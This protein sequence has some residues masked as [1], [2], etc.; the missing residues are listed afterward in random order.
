ME[1]KEFYLPCNG[2]DLH[3]K[4]EFPK[5]SKDKYPLMIVV[6]GLTGHMEERHIRAEAAALNDHGYATLRVEL[7]G[8][9]KSGGEFFDHTV[10]LWVQ[11]LLQIIDYAASLD[12]VTD[13]YITGHS[14]GGAAVLLAGS[15]KE[16]MLKGIILQAPAML[17]KDVAL[18]G[19]M[20]GNSFDPLH[21]PK[22][23]P[24][25][26]QEVS[27]NYLRINQLLPLEAAVERICGPIQIIHS[28]A[29]EGVPYHYAQ[30][31]AEQIKQAELIT[32]PGDNHVFSQHIDMVI[33]AMLRF[34]EKISK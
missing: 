34:L 16:D 4:L 32:I 9:G 28:D 30:E 11:E 8:H 27:G 29:D 12:F 15:L 17:L 23:F 21:V 19:E 18:A 5:E 3:M 25:N 20:L 13:L 33:E 2:T 6:H 14:Q 22:T 31:L 10:I 24:I 7:Y 1:N 26:G